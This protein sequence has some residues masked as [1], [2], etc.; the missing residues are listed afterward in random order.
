[1]PLSNPEVVTIGPVGA[2]RWT[3]GSIGLFITLAFFL[4]AVVGAPESSSY[5][6]IMLGLSTLLGCG[7]F[8][9][10]RSRSSF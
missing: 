3:G 8:L 10:H 7:L 1:M 4:I 9:W 2:G 5:L 6:A